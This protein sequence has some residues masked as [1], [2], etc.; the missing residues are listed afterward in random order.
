MT[1]I[2]VTMLCEAFVDAFC[3]ANG[4]CCSDDARVYSSFETCITDQL[5]RCHDDALGFE[6]PERIAAMTV[7]YSQGAAGGEYAS[8]ATMGDMCIPIRY[9]DEILDTYRGR[10]ARGDACTHDVECED[11]GTC[12]DSGGIATCI[13][14]PQRR[15]PCTDNEQC[16]ASDLRCNAGECDFRLA[17]DE[18]CTRDDDCETLHCRRGFCFQATA[19]STYCVDIDEPGPAF[20]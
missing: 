6:F 10:I 2:P 18:A 8:L 1:P 20:E 4:L 11:D 16:V 14:A 7:D 13:G 17:I 3:R 15:D 12:L 19:D 5:M 9:G